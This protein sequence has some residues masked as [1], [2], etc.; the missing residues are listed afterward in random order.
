MASEH[1]HEQATLVVPSAGGRPGLLLRPWTEQDIPALLAAHR[2]PLLRRWLR[3]LLTT[4]QEA[5]ELIE[6]QRANRRA[7][8]AFGFAIML[9]DPAGG[10]ATLAGSVGV[11]GLGAESVA[12][13]VGYWV[14]APAR[15]RGIAGQALSAVREWVFGLPLARPL[16]RLDLIHTVGNQASCRVADKAGF[17]LSATL[18]PL[19]PEFPGTGHLHVWTP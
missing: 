4:E 11:R 9:T 3:R 8:S 15:G 13:E 10:P 6:A 16:E 7:G 5:R 12:G 18:P 14:A 19:P 1:Q 2:D 17:R